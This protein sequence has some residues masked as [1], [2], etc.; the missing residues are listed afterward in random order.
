MF[1]NTWHLPV[2]RTLQVLC[3]A[4]LYL[5]HFYNSFDEEID[6]ANKD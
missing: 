1:V 4:Y 5:T 2:L 3:F 6:T